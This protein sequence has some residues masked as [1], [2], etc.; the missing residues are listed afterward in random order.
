MSGSSSHLQVNQNHFDNVAHK[1]D[2]ANSL[3]ER[4]MD[5]IADAIL[6]VYDFDEDET[7]VLDFACG[8]IN[9]SNGWSIDCLMNDHV[10]RTGDHD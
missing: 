7:V 9:E 10:R 6:D 4:I 8:Y 1:Y 5:D 2:R 3:R